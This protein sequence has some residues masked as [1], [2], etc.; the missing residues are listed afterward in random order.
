MR[1]LGEAVA[2][3]TMGLVSVK[4]PEQQSIMMLHRVRLMLNHPRTRRSNA[5][6]VYL[7]EFSIVASIGRNGIEQLLAV[8]NDETIPGCRPLKRLCYECLMPSLPAR[9]RRRP[10]LRCDFSWNEDPV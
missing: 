7:S 9:R 10:A 4:T 2:R 1:K 3:P 8:I 6:R 5:L